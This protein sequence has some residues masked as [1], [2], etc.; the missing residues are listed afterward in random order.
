MSSHEFYMKLALESAAAMKG[1]TD[2]NPL[3]G[4]VIVNH[5]RI[6]GIGA[7]LKAGGPHAEIHALRMAGE[8][9][10]GGTIYVT[11]E[12]CSHHGRTGPCAEAIVAAGIKRVVIAAGDPN[13]LVS[14][15]GISILEGAGI[16]VISG[17]LEQESVRMNEVFNKYIA[18][19]LPFVTLKSGITLDGKIASRSNHSKW[20]TSEEARLD[21]QRMR[22]ENKAILVGVGTVIHDDPSLTARIPNGRNPIRV[23]MD[24]TLRIPLGAKVIQDREAETWIFTGSRYDVKK[25]ERLKELGIKVFTTNSPSGVDP[26]QLLHTLGEK[27]VSSLLIEGGGTVNAA[28]L[29]QGLVDKVVL[30]LAPKIIG[31]RNAPTFFEGTGFEKMSD[32]LEFKDYSMTPVGPDFKF[33]GYP[34]NPSMKGPGK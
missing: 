27:Q 9:A 8:E 28:F 16:E 6:V 1:Q 33:I 22:N 15:R 2:P 25:M 14:G 19:Q 18:E 5:N 29:E 20:I 34:G 30:Y 11:L 32:A 21:V 4:S 10:A 24:T 26:V 31:G 23:I 17:I 13:P 7:H 12:P 3:V